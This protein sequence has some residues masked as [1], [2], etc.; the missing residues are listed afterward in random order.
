MFKKSIDMKK[1]LMMMAV[2]MIALAGCKGK[3]AKQGEEHAC[4]KCMD[5]RW[6]IVKVLD[7]EPSAALKDSV[8]FVF[9]KA[10]I[11]FDK[12]L[13]HLGYAKCPLFLSKLIKQNIQHSSTEIT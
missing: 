3:Q 13:S 6:S 9:N 8:A 4:D 1:V 5:G 2:A 10:D 7:V 12:D 11:Q